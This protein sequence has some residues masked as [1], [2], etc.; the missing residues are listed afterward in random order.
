MINLRYTYS[1]LP[2]ELYSEQPVYKYPNA[3]VL[4]FNEVLAK[5]LG[6]DFGAM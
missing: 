2:N 3:K 6:L 1:E 5:D 4:A